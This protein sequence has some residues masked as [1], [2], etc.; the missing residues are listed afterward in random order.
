VQAHEALA[1]QGRER[2][3]HRRRADAEAPRDLDL[4]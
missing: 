1:L 4:A 3:A 2:L